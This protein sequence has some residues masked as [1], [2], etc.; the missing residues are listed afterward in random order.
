MRDRL[1]EAPPALRRELLSRLIRKFDEP[2][3]EPSQ[4]ASKRQ[5][6]ILRQLARLLGKESVPQD[7]GSEET[8]EKV[9]KAFNTVFDSLN[10][11]IGTINLTLLGR[12]EEMETIRHVI[13]SSI[14]GAGGGARALNDHL[15]QIQRA[16]LVAHK[17]FQEAA[18]TKVGQF[19]AE[20]DP[21]KLEAGAEGGLKFGALRKA[22]LF[23]AYT[24]KYKT[25]QGWLSSGRFREE[26]LRE[27]EKICQKLYTSEQRGRT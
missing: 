6:M 17:A 27:F 23:D 2:A 22:E 10:G 7:A 18:Q 16:F 26:L 12:K 8:A 24:D 4:L 21:V 1:G 14:D 3:A 9:L 13:V 19:L 20:L 11:I 25:C 15:E 5:E